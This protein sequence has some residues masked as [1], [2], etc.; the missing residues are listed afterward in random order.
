MY[1][2]YVLP[3]P[4]P[5]SYP[6]DHFT[7]S[8]LCLFF[9]SLKINQPTK[10]Q[11]TYAKKTF[12]KNTKPETKIESKRLIRPKCP[13]K[14]ETYKPVKIPLSLFCIGHPLL[15]M[16]PTLNMIIKSFI[17]KQIQKVDTYFPHFIDVIVRVSLQ[18]IENDTSNLNSQSLL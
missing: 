12:Y 6:F 10:L 13:K 18:E 1:S 15:G 8:T 3:L 17:S 11:E 14:Y 9:F 4:Q 2:N 5:L 16:R 7:Y